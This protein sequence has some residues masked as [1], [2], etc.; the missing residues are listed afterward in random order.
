[1]SRIAFA[2]APG[3]ASHPI[4]KLTD[5]ELTRVIGGFESAGTS[6]SSKSSSSSTCDTTK[7]CCCPEE[8]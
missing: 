7:K 6:S 5:E 3:G 8:N 1:M 2:Q 4:V